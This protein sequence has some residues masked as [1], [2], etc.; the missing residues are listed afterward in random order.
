MAQTKGLP[1]YTKNDSKRTPR[2]LVALVAL[3]LFALTNLALPSWYRNASTN[4]PV[5]AAQILKQCDQLDQTPHPPIDFQ[6]RTQ[7]DRY[8]PGTRAVLLRN[9]TIWT[10]AAG[11]RQVRKGDVLLDKGIIRA[12]GKMTWIPRDVE[13]VDVH[14]AW[15]SPGIVDMHSHLG[16]DSA[17]A[18]R[19]ASDTNSLKGLILPWL[20][21][22]DGLNTHDAAYALSVSGGVTTSLVLPGSAD[23]IGGQAFTIKLR[24]TEERS[25]SA[26]L[27]EPP[28]SLNG[29]D[30]AL[31]SDLPPRWRQMKHACGENPARVYSGTRMDNIWA[32]RQGYETARKIKTDQDNYC[33]AARD[34]RWNGLGAFPQSLQWEALVDVLRGRVKV[35]THCYEAVDLDGLVRLSNEFKFPIAAVHHAHEAYLV[36]DLLKK[37]Y[38]HTPAVALFATHA[39]Y[40]REAYR[41][42]E[43][44]PRILAENGFNVVMKSDH[45]VT[46]SRHLLYEA[47]QAHYYG[48]PAHLAL[49]AVT[50]TPARAMGLD[51]RIGLV[52]EG[53]DAD[54]IVWDSHPLAL[55]AAPTQV[56]IDGIAQLAA[57]SVAQKPAS[58]QHPPTPPDF[59]DEAAEAVAH[60]GLPPL[61][62]R[63][64]VHGRV[65]FERVSKV[66]VRGGSEPLTD[67]AGVVCVK[68]GSVF[69]IGAA[70]CGAEFDSAERIDLKGGAISPGLV[71]FG[72]PLGLEEISAESSTNDGRSPSEL[73]EIVGGASAVLHA[74]DGLQFSGRDA[75]LAYRSGVTSAVS[76]PTKR[77]LIQ[78]LTV[79]FSTGAR[80]R[81]E[82]GAIAS[83]I[84]ALHVALGH[85][86]TDSV[87][88]QI[89]TLRRFLLGGATGELGARFADVAKGALPLVV[90]VQNADIMATLLELKEEV[91]AETGKKIRLTFTAAQ[92]AH[93]LAK[94][95]GEAGVGVI[96]RAVRP[97]PSSWESQ[98]ILPGPPLSKENAVSVLLAHNVTVGVGVVD[99]T[100][101]RSLRFDV[102]WAA[103]EAG[104]AISEVE[105]L[106]LASINIENLLGAGGDAARGDLVATRGAGLLEFESKIVAIISPQRGVTDLL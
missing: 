29:T 76:A 45:P 68:D 43:F 13:I 82:R 66:I 39:R 98:R 70:A 72:P 18:L 63:R 42:S 80:H 44:A 12:V 77:G 61:H 21:S 59:T 53:H 55:G 99:S 67:T 58:V 106:A 11:G 35:H 22:V 87:G 37:A 6:T 31:E 2:L 100:S 52:E 97:F 3:A 8:V 91:E 32:F 94:E 64:A 9:A 26:M 69:G 10:G 20:R 51:H 74:A 7:S 104:G 33:A 79:S 103:L 96:L 101:A 102:G 16:V 89:A 75:L 73:P 49:S 14:G 90:E 54:I 46:N 48:L 1:P 19:G 95:I 93:L 60:D 36:P 71:A 27:L 84:T 34:G 50:I 4:P 78:G 40:K 5:N 62:A 24:P 28:F 41:G 105:A 88:T 38:G 81:L 83:G 30:A 23:A 92:E 17:P 86:R 25:S 15:V 56:Y 47:Q 65:V 85:G 57:P